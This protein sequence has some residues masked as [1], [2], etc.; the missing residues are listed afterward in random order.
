MVKTFRTKIFIYLK[1]HVNFTGKLLRI[2]E[3]AVSISAVSV[4]IEGCLVDF[5]INDYNNE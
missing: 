4:N 5:T 2:A 1:H 3:E